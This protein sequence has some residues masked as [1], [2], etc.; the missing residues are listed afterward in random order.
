MEAESMKFER[1]DVDGENYLRL[2]VRAEEEEIKQD[3]EEQFKDWLWKNDLIIIII[4]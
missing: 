2:R 4:Y 1:A 3:W